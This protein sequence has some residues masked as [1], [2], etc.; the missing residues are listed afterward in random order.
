MTWWRRRRRRWSWSLRGKHLLIAFLHLVVERKGRG[1]RNMVA[2]KNMVD[3][4]FILEKC[5]G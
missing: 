4:R 1:I 2:E 5:S 3:G